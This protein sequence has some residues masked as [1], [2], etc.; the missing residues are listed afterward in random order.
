MEQPRD[1]MQSLLAQQEVGQRSQFA[2]RR[3]LE[4]EPTPLRLL[5]NPTGFP[6][7]F[8]LARAERGGWFGREQ[9]PARTGAI[10]EL[11]RFGIS[12]TLC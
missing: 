8:F 7:G 1:P 5:V 10:F 6:A 11:D 2:G 9:R 12:S 4:S 3:S